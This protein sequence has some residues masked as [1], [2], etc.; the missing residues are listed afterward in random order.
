MII[1]SGRE[2]VALSGCCMAVRTLKPYQASARVVGSSF[3]SAS[4]PKEAENH[5]DFRSLVGHV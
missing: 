4:N 2:T 1:K 3:H 5:L